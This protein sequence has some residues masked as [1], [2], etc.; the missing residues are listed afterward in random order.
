MIKLS[1]YDFDSVQQL[2]EDEK[3]FLAIQIT[4]PITTKDYVIYHIVL[5][6]MRRCYFVSGLNGEIYTIDNGEPYF[7][8]YRL[9]DWFKYILEANEKFDSDTMY[10]NYFDAN[11]KIYYSQR[12][13]K[14][15][16]IVNKPW[17]HEHCEY[18]EHFIPDLNFEEIDMIIYPNEFHNKPF[19]KYVRQNLI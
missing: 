2:C 15:T 4:L 11:A 14:R 8:N 5:I 6:F 13:T 7:N 17:T 9:Y 19:Y 18:Y 10:F 3:E 16:Q 12:K 1:I